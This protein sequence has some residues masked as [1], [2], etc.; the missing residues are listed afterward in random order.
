[1]S[2]NQIR[3]YFQD[4]TLGIGKAIMKCNMSQ[5]QMV[6]N[7]I[8]PVPVDVWNWYSSQIIQYVTES[9]FFTNG[10]NDPRNHDAMKLM[11]PFGN[12]WI[13]WLSDSVTYWI[14]WQVY[15]FQSLSRSKRFLIV[16]SLSDAVSVLLLTRGLPP[17]HWMHNHAVTTARSW[18]L[19]TWRMTGRG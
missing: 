15:L 12:Y 11:T 5:N 8:M 14:L 3:L 18:W 7:P 4:R 1:M 13:L 2:H 9:E 17:G 6:T 16:G 19:R 10:F